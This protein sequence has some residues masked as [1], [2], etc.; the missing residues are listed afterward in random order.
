LWRV[1]GLGRALDL[2]LTGRA[3]DAVEAERIGLVNRIV[4]DGQAKSAAIALAEEIA[5]FPWPTVLA[6]RAS[7]Y[8]GIGRPL[9]EGIAIEARR[10]MSV[11]GTGAEGAARF[12]SGKGRHGAER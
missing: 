5:S 12:A 2:M 1:V 3:I 6:D 4:D 7:L 8:D 9:E 10:G 11:L